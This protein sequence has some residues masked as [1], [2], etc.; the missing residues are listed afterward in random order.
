MTGSNR[1]SGSPYLLAVYEP[2]VG[3]DGTALASPIESGR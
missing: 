3:D 2:L 1:G